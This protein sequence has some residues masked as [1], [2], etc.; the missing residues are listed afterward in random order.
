MSRNI[1]NF[2]EC[3]DEELLN[4]I[5][6]LVCNMVELDES[7]IEYLN[8]LLVEAKTRGLRNE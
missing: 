8:C 5:D 4:E 6:N 3:T 7:E 2:N 1:V